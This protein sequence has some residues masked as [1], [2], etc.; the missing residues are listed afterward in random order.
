[1][2][3]KSGFAEKYPAFGVPI[4]LYVNLSRL[5]VIDCHLSSISHH[6][7]AQEK[8]LLC[9]CLSNLNRLAPAPRSRRISKQLRMTALLQTHKPKHRLLNRL[10]TSQQAMVLQQR[11]FL[12]AERFSNILALY[13]SKHDAVERFVEHVVV[14]ERTAILRDCV[15]LSAQ[16]AEAPPVDT[17][18]VRCGVDVGSGLVDG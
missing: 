9:L 10:A 6:R 13:F 12:I 7:T 3:S 17:V 5:S 1:M 4:V 2:V 15:Q 18:A 16:A 8:D 11:R 14:V